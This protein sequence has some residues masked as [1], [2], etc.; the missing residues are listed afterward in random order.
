MDQIYRV[1]LSSLSIE[2]LEGLGPGNQ[3]VDI[4]YCHKLKDFSSLR[5]CTTVCIEYCSNFIDASPL[6][7]VKS[8]SVITN[9]LAA[10]LNGAHKLHY[11]KSIF[12]NDLYTLKSL[13]SVK[14]VTLWI[15][16]SL[17][18]IEWLSWLCDYS[19]IEKITINKNEDGDAN[20]IKRSFISDM[21]N[22]ETM[23]AHFTVESD[24]DMD[25][26]LRRRNKLKVG[27]ISSIK[28]QLSN[29]FLR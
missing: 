7:G 12:K 26:L 6:R 11:L 14:E 23:L 17:I 8:L 16:P 28:N 19:H 18:N 20:N 15:D 1:I 25:I 10:T 9:T 29:L 24:G 4:R 13:T 21:R 5:L 22:K 3:V 2:S 27:V